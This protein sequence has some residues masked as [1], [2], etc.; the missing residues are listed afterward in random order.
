MK[1]VVLLA[2]ALVSAVALPGCSGS[3]A[4]ARP[5]AS[6]VDCL[7]ASVA[8]SGP[9]AAPSD[10]A[11][12]QPL[13]ELELPCLDGGH[14]AQVAGIRGPA[15]V[16][17]WASWCGPC[18]TELPAFQRYAQ[19]AAGTVRVIGVSSDDRADA[20]RALV[21]DLHLTFP[22]LF[23]EDARLLA[24]S[25]KIALPVT[26]FVDATGRIRYVYNA[27]PLDEPGLSALVAQHLGIAL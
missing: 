3:H 9:T 14:P 6:G 19:R 25:G 24:A 21:R 17:L 23:D 27:Q 2:V 16:N 15:L 8:P 26:L 5:S 12:G 20:S 4:T 13:P 11:G 10:P 22:M 1:R 7:A 18:R